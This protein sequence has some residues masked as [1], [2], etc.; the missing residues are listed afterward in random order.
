MLGWGEGEG[1]QLGSSP[2]PMV[3]MHSA[4]WSGQACLLLPKTH[5]GTGHAVSD[6]LAALRALPGQKLGR[7][8][9]SGPCSVPQ[10]WA[11]GAGA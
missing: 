8:N 9:L 5:P 10:S 6:Q 3:D 1:H 11:Q 2:F 7:G 4:A